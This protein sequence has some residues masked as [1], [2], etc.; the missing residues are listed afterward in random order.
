MSAAIG[1]GIGIFYAGLAYLTQRRAVRAEGSGFMSIVIGGMLLR[2][3]LLLVL[4]GLVLALIEVAVLPF[5]G[6][7][8]L[9]L[10]LGLG[11]DAWWMFRHLQRPGPGRDHTA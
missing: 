9:F 8:V 2:M 1:A 5:V 7:L 11:F 4:V 3:V 10:L 6:V